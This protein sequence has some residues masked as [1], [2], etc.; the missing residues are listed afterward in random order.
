MSKMWYLNITT[1]LVVVIGGVLGMIK[2]DIEMHIQGIQRNTSLPERQK[3]VLMSTDHI[4]RKLFL[5]YAP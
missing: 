5:S 1:V 2:K 4:L 3:I